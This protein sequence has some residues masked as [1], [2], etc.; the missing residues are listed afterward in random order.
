M[1]LRVAAGGGE[2]LDWS[3]EPL[4]DLVESIRRQKFLGPCRRIAR[5]D[6][7]GQLSAAPHR[8]MVLKMAPGRP[9]EKALEGG[10]GLC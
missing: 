5:G 6:V 2:F 8:L 10:C 3:A 4:L 7:D 1:A 9:R